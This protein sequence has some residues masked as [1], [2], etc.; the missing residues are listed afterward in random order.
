MK[1]DKQDSDIAKTKGDA[2]I[3]NIENK[4][5]R[6]LNFV[7]YIG[8]YTEDSIPN[9]NTGVNIITNIGG[10]SQEN[11]I[12]SVETN[13]STSVEADSPSINTNYVLPKTFRTVGLLPEHWDDHIEEKEKRYSFR[14]RKHFTRPENKRFSRMKRIVA[15]I[16]SKIM[17]MGHEEVLPTIERFYSIKKQSLPALCDK[18]TEITK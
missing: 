15:V 16:K 14:W 7:S 8:R 1:K 4:V 11:T 2:T 3:K 18:L 9:E 13:N 10:V 6:L 12:N 17:E 5:D